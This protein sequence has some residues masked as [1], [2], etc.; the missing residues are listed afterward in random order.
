MSL[1][2]TSY[3]LKVEGGAVNW[4][5][6]RLHEVRHKAR[7]RNSPQRRKG[8]KVE[9]AAKKK[10][11]LNQSLRLCAFAGNFFLNTAASFLL[12]H[13]RD[14]VVAQDAIDLAATSVQ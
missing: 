5:C 12:I 4:R 14:L 11:L 13:A 1:I 8:A 9:P 6:S 7:S 2:V 10:V 3:D